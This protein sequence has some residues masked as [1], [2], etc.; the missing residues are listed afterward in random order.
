MSSYFFYSEGSDWPSFLRNARAAGCNAVHTTVVWGAHEQ[1]PDVY[2]FIRPSANLIKFAQMAA[3]NDLFLIL[4]IWPAPEARP[5]WRNGGLPAWLHVNLLDPFEAASTAAR[6][7]R[8]RL[9]KWLRVLRRILKPVSAGE[10]GPLILLQVESS[11]AFPFFVREV[12]A[13]ALSSSMST[14]ATAL[15]VDSL[16][17]SSQHAFSEDRSFGRQKELFF[18]ESGDSEANAADGAA[19]RHHATGNGSPVGE[20]AD[21]SDDCLEEE[22]DEIEVD[23][24]QFRDLP[25]DGQF[26]RNLQTSDGEVPDSEQRGTEAGLSGVG[27]QKQKEPEFQGRDR[28]RGPGQPKKTVWSWFVSFFASR[29]NQRK[30]TVERTASAGGTNARSGDGAG[31]RESDEAH[32]TGS[33]GLNWRKCSPA[34]ILS[35]L[36]LRRRE[37]DLSQRGADGR[38]DAVPGTHE[39]M[40][41]EARE[42]TE[43]AVHA[44]GSDADRSRPCGHRD[45]QSRPSFA[46]CAETRDFQSQP[47]SH[48]SI[49]S[50][51]KETTDSPLRSALWTD[52]GK[53]IRTCR[54][55]PISSWGLG[56]RYWRSDPY[57]RARQVLG[58]EER[59]EVR[60]RDTE[61]ESG[62]TRRHAREFASPKGEGNA[63]EQW[64]RR[65]GKG[66]M[67]STGRGCSAPE[68]GRLPRNGEDGTLADGQSTRED[69]GRDRFCSGWAKDKDRATD[70]TTRDFE[71]IEQMLKTRTRRSQKRLEHYGLDNRALLHSGVSEVKA[72]ARLERSALCEGPNVQESKEDAEKGDRQRRGACSVCTAGR[73]RRGVWEELHETLHLP[74]VFSITLGE[75]GDLDE[76]EGAFLRTLL[77][78]N[79]GVDGDAPL[80]GG[81]FLLACTGHACAPPRGGIRGVPGSRVPSRRFLLGRPRNATERQGAALDSL[82]AP[83]TSPAFSDLLDPK[84]TGRFSWRSL[85]GLPPKLSEDVL[86]SLRATRAAERSNGTPATSVPDSAFAESSYSWERFLR[87]FEWRTISSF[88][89]SLLHGRRPSLPPSPYTAS[90]PF[91]SSAGVAASQPERIARGATWEASTAF[92][93]V[94]V[95]AL[96]DVVRFFAY[97]GTVLSHVPFIET[98]P[99]LEDDPARRAVVPQPLEPVSAEVS[100]ASCGAFSPECSLQTAPSPAPCPSSERLSWGTAEAG[101]GG[102]VAALTFAGRKA[103]APLNVWASP[104]T[105]LFEV[106]VLLHRFLG[107]ASGNLLER[108][109]Y[110]LPVFRSAHVELFPFKTVDIIC[111]THR[112]RTIALSG[113]RGRNRLPLSPLSCYGY[114][115]ATGTPASAAPAKRR[116]RLIYSTALYRR[117]AVKAA[118]AF[119]EDGDQGRRQQADAHARHK[120]SQREGGKPSR[121]N[122]ASYADLFAIADGARLVRPQ[123]WVQSMRRVDPIPHA[124]AVTSALSEGPAFCLRDDAPAIAWVGRLSVLAYPQRLAQGWSDFI[125]YE[126]NLVGP[127]DTRDAQNGRTTNRGTLAS[128]Q[129]RLVAADAP[130][131]LAV[132][133]S[134]RSSSVYVFSERGALLGQTVSDA[135]RDEPW[136][137]ARGPGTVAPFHADEVWLRVQIPPG[138][139]KVIILSSSV[140]A[141]NYA[142]LIQ[143]I[144]RP[145]WRSRLRRL[146]CSFLARMNS[147]CRWRAKSSDAE[148]FHLQGQ[149]P[150]SMHE[151]RWQS[152]PLEP[153]KRCIGLRREPQLQ[154]GVALNAFLEMWG[155]APASQQ[156]A[157]SEGALTVKPF[158]SAPAL[159]AGPPGDH[160]YADRTRQTVVR[161]IGDRH[162]SG[163]NNLFQWSLFVFDMPDG[164]I[165]GVYQVLKITSESNASAES[166]GHLP[167]IK[168]C[169]TGRKGR[170]YVNSQFAGYYSISGSCTHGTPPDPECGTT[171]ALV[172]IP[173]DWVKPGLNYVDLLEEKGGYGGGVSIQE[174]FHGGHAAT[175]AWTECLIV[176]AVVLLVWLM[177]LVLVGILLQMCRQKYQ[178]QGFSVQEVIFRQ[179]V[180]SINPSELES[181]STSGTVSPVHGRGNPATRARH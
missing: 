176:G 142:S 114:E 25:S 120:A 69:G 81:A 98:N 73:R 164:R 139:R 42:E 17:G 45:H 9:R 82:A 115:K 163:I 52:G 177:A 35:T 143:S 153:S 7:Q 126:A 132:R 62:D 118:R 2:D 180:Q 28:S 179:I 171:A 29:P 112:K 136:H 56:P 141:R 19:R 155:F 76:A 122:R 110:T 181:P 95:E 92:T 74:F 93:D 94:P 24:Q 72:G 117:H 173:T 70:Q 51:V 33:P 23:E 48:A 131:V 133:C 46:G 89:S 130:G 32:N 154:S 169:C 54:V 113:G 159:H 116:S 43:T 84:T 104:Q 144:H 137:T 63:R 158:T 128:G 11:A 151:L 38:P 121:T 150:A 4:N 77:D 44:D 134:E 71:L 67:E 149:Q 10:G 156:H 85:L 1:T 90:P 170:A 166:H 68:G 49:S 66:Q 124:T 34:R 129:E 15:Q 57:L 50:E 127:Q 5:E 61:V 20:D 41:K 8:S 58:L 107:H 6:R 99:A 40:A 37:V 16:S 78:A 148:Q 30:G 18:E 31:I 175:L 105:P 22:G 88:M 102:R 135:V 111:N 65:G 55:R 109:S 119:A 83:T 123:V 14:P 80:A 86:E 138:V 167:R 168:D 101:D 152:L 103:R 160:E 162:R 125:W 147:L 157:T 75:S 91:S 21:E 59:C 100:P 64:E 172:K 13:P 108:P 145:S 53:R 36:K 79:L 12:F 47:C 178:G 3:A 97:G 60:R 174:E 140:G 161:S 26:P 39:R 27:P 87:L 146:A 165:R 96:Q 106:L